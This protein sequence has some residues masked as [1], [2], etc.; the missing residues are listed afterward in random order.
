MPLK[1]E[2][3]ENGLFLQ[4]HFALHYQ[5]LSNTLWFYENDSYSERYVF[6]PF[7]KKTDTFNKNKRCHV[8]LEGLGSV[9]AKLKP[10]SS[11]N[12]EILEI[13]VLHK[14]TSHALYK[15]HIF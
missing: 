9:C 1:L 12:N 8:T 14:F 4:N 11:K 10:V 5:T 7:T 3:R 13:N 6:S 15:A 2:K